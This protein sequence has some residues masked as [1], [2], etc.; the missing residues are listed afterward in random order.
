MDYRKNTNFDL[1]IRI[2]EM[3]LFFMHIKIDLNGD[4]FGVVQIVSTD[5]IGRQ[6]QYE[7]KIESGPRSSGYK[8]IV[9]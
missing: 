2:V 7:L 3:G 1:A 6:F 4:L 9:S 8:Q 5:P